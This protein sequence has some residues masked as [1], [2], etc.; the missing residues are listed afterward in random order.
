MADDRDDFFGDA[1]GAGRSDDADRWP[2]NAE[3]PAGDTA[4]P[5]TGMSGAV[6]VLLILL[7][8]FVLLAVAC[9]GAGIW[10]FTQNVKNTTDPVTIR[11]WTQEI[12]SIDI[13]QEQYTPAVGVKMNVFGQFSMDMVVYTGPGGGTLTLA[14]I[15]GEAANDPNA[16]QQLDMQMR[17][18]GA[19]HQINVKESETRTFEI[20]G[21][22]VDFTF[23]S[24][25]E[26]QSG[27]E[28]REVTGT[29]PGKDGIVTFKLQEPSSSFDE[30][31]VT[32][33]IESISAE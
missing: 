9:C 2:M 22:E 27:D 21:E 24:G 23:A 4:A 33:M 14:N 6:K 28:W 13:P 7:A 29:F 15:G 30:E 20:G 25:T 1:H 17:Q 10:W 26:T 19:A 32:S 18:Q 12:V 3:G 5:R 16:R 31:Q 11:T 8:V